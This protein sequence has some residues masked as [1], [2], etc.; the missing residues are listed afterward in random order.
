M[1]R[2]DPHRQQVRR[3]ASL[4]RMS[5]RKR[6]NS[7]RRPGS[8]YS[9]SLRPRSLR[10]LRCMCSCTATRR[11]ESPRPPRWEVACSRFHMLRSCERRLAGTRPHRRART[12]RLQA[13]P[14]RL[15]RARPCRE[16]F[17]RPISRPRSG[18]HR[19]RHHRRHPE[20]S[21][22]RS[23]TRGW[24]ARLRLLHKREA[25][26]P[27]ARPP[28]ASNPKRRRSDRSHAGNRHTGSFRASFEA[29]KSTLSPVRPDGRRCQL[30]CHSILCIAL[31]TALVVVSGVTSIAIP[32]CHKRETARKRK[33]RL[34]CVRETRGPLL[35]L[36]FLARPLNRM[37]PRSFRFTSTVAES[38]FESNRSTLRTM[39]C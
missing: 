5:S 3:A 27:R 32:E 11:S 37:I 24:F 23:A 25:P 39:L 9:Q 18:L 14:R 30:P 17:R 7:S 21:H 28:G 16:R 20:R 29:C 38:V 33:L 13:G 31:L 22:R 4:R 12:A 8:W 26:T 35:N 2:F 10:S 36:R 15:H 1:S 19:G 6:R 34:A